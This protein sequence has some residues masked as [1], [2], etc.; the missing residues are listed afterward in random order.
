[1]EEGEKACVFVYYQSCK[2]ALYIVV[3]WRKKTGSNIKQREQNGAEI[4][5]LEKITVTWE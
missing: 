2:K 3:W 4:R 1:V 5:E